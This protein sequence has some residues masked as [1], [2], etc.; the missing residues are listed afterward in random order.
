MTWSLA[1]TLRRLAAPVLAGFAFAVGVAAQ[2]PRATV[3]E[4]QRRATL[5]AARALTDDAL[6]ALLPRAEAGEVETQVLVALALE[7]RSGEKNRAAA[8]AWFQRAAGAG[9][10]MALD[11]LASY[12]TTGVVV[13]R[14]RARA[15]ALRQQ[16]AESGYASAQNQLGVAYHLGD[17]VPTNPQTAVAW[18]RR[19]AEQ[20]HID[21]Q[22]NLAGAYDTGLAGRVD[23]TEAARWL[24]RA[25][26]QGDAQAQFNLGI[27]YCVGEGV[28]ERRDDCRAWLKRASDQG[29]AAATFYL[30]KDHAE[31]SFV[32]G[33]FAQAVAD[34]YFA[35]SATQGYALGAVVLA[36]RSRARTE[37]CRWLLVASALE[38]RAD[39]RGGWT[40]R[41]P[42]D[43]EEV[44]K[45]LARRLKDARKG[46]TPEQVNTC[47]REAQG[48]VAQADATITALR[49]QREALPADERGPERP[50]VP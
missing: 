1:Q 19:A 18:Y 9:H 11:A 23:H 36:R 39:W 40:T 46:L 27:A 43:A 13:A 48:F 49:L 47:E 30:A 22:N 42:W 5:A 32:A 3:T 4:T 10:P 37:A 41:R 8:V 16:A 2:E 7:S 26:D 28:A 45:E 44:R 12:H 31:H 21:G 14:D 34:D 24:R 25:A 50:A 20:G 6:S 38:S 17:G 29:Y 15:I 33:P 35:K